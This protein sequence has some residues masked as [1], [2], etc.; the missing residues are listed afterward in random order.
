MLSI[1]RIGWF[2]D[3][4][5]KMSPIISEKILNFRDRSVVL[6]SVCPTGY[7]VP[8]ETELATETTDTGVANRDDVASFLKLPSADQCISSSGTAPD[9]SVV[10][11][12]WSSSADGS[13]SRNLLFYLDDIDWHNGGRAFGRSVRCLKH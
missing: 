6:V 7:R 3:R 8:T 12:V 10:G 11:Y 9:T 5:D 4:Y 1:W 2:F 13:R